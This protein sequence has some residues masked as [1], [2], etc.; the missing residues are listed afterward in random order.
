MKENIKKS[1]SSV[2]F[3]QV[4]EIWYVAFPR[5]PLPSLLKRCP[6]AR[7]VLGLKP[8]NTYKTI[9]ELFLQNH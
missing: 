8:R 6:R 1:S 5:G 2:P 3:F 7:G 4:L 9:Q